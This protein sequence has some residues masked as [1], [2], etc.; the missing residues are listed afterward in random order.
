M[1]KKISS[2]LNAI[3]ELVNLDQPLEHSDTRDKIFTNA[4]REAAEFQI[5]YQPA[6]AAYCKMLGFFP[7]ML[8]SIT[9]IPKTPPII[10]NVFKRHK[11]LT[12]P[13]EDMV[14][15]LQSSGTTRGERSH[16]FVDDASLVRLQKMLETLFQT[17][18]YISDEPTNYLI[19]T[20][21]PEEASDLG[22]AWTYKNL[23]RF[24]PANRV[25][26]AIKK[27]FKGE[28][29][30]RKDIVLQ[31]LEEFKKEGLNIR[32]MGIPSFMYEIFHEQEWKDIPK[33]NFGDKAKVITG[34]GWKSYAEKEIPKEKF[35][36]YFSDLLGI[37]QQNVRDTFGS[38]EHAAPY[39]ECELHEFH[40]PTYSRVYAR[41][42]K[43][44]MILPYGVPGLLNFVSPYLASMPTIS[45]L[46]MDTGIVEESGN[47]GR[48]G[49]IFRLTG[50]AG[51]TKHIGCAI[52]ASQMLG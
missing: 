21:D 26:Y 42:P 29:E 5:E 30:F 2:E 23:R 51:I 27:N 32:I 34:G 38:I 12:L 17:L 3:N 36:H 49:P 50:R 31:T 35:I 39:L 22:T 9:D 48:K 8:R 20:Y 41:D 24:A 45:I 11:L 43:T 40:I 10:A 44:L 37:P 15:H 18:G 19:F 14:L 46:S 1:T 28:F 25:V 13:E 33:F 52:T 47:C 7:K 16:F 4:M 6:Y